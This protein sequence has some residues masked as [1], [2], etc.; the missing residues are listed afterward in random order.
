MNAGKHK[1]AIWKARKQLEEVCVFLEDSLHNYVLQEEVALLE[2][3]I[4]RE[5]EYI[6]RE[7]RVY[8]KLQ[9]IQEG[10]EVSKIVFDFLKKKV[11]V[12]KMLWIHRDDGSLEEDPFGIRGMFSGHF[13]NIFSLANPLTKMIV[14][15]I[16]AH[17]RVMQQKVSIL[18]HDR[19]EKKFTKDEHFPSLSSMKNS[20]S[21]GFDRVSCDLYKAM[22]DI[23][24]D[25]FSHLDSK[26]IALRCLKW[27]INQGLIKFIPKKCSHVHHSGLVTNCFIKC[28]LQ[29]HGKEV[30]F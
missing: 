26:D 18:D 30:T 9:W 16:N 2:S 1:K 11:I 24:G 5:E 15:A 19:L 29:N 25:D 8:A 27:S 17:Y 7:A 4:R 10:D 12:D 22:W 6:T 14:A 3:T 20:K 28:C 23:V 13:K 21:L